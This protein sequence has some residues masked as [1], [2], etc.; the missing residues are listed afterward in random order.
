MAKGRKSIPSK[1]IEL[2]GGTKHTHK[3]PRDQEPKPPEKM[4][5]CPKHLDD[6]A[7]KEWRRAGKILQGVGL[8]TGLDMAVLAGYCQS[9]SEW[10][11][12]TREIPVKGPVW[13]GPDGIPKLNPWL[14]VAREAYDRW[15]KAAVLLGLS[16]SSRATLKI[17]KPKPQSKAEKFMARKNGA[18]G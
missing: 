11:R 8:M 12:A 3:K 17:E 1:I 4:P 18:K 9:Y 16:P 13:V 10:A 6:D 15:M 14:R 5:K 7:R 2:R